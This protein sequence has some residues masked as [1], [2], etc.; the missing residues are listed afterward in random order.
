MVPNTQPPRYV[1]RPEFNPP[2]AR[3]LP[4]H[5]SNDLAKI[6][7]AAIPIF[8]NLQDMS[9][10]M[11]DLPFQAELLQNA[12]NPMA[13]EVQDIGDETLLLPTEGVVEQEQ[14]A[15]QEIAQIFAKNIDLGN[16]LA[17]QKIQNGATAQ[18]TPEKENA[19]ESPEKPSGQEPKKIVIA[20]AEQGVNFGKFFEKGAESLI[21]NPLNTSNP[22]AVEAEKRA[23]KEENVPGAKTAVDE[24]SKSLKQ[25]DWRHLTASDIPLQKPPQVPKAERDGKTT[26]ISGS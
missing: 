11:T 9:D 5:M 26:G 8:L 6:M 1:T 15:L 21:K 23:G 24:K 14:T 4:E 18:Q 7:A 17:G 25:H 12:E 3:P 20:Q 16:P 2:P 10:A 19:K 22:I 13:E